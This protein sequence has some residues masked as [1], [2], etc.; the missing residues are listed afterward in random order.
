M[1]VWTITNIP[2]KEIIKA[3][4]VLVESARKFHSS[5]LQ[6]SD[7]RKDKDTVVEDNQSA[8]MIDSRLRTLEDDA[9]AQAEIVS[10]M[11]EQ[12]EAL[13]IGLQTLSARA[14]M[15]M[16]VACGSTAIAVVAIVFSVI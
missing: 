16:W 8:V 11:A 2:W 9:T 1:A 4:P 10:R 3:V 15:L 7:T 13:S 14:T 12:V 6:R 5:R